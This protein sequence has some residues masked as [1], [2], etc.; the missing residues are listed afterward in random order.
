[1]RPCLLPFARADVTPY[2]SWPPFRYGGSSSVLY[3]LK[4]PCQC[5]LPTTL[6]LSVLYLKTPCN[7]PSFHGIPLLIFRPRCSGMPC[8]ECTVLAMEC[9]DATILTWLDVSENA[10]TNMFTS[11][12]L[13]PST[14][15]LQTLFATHPL[16]PGDRHG[17]NSPS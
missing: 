17:F 11:H 10:W 4:A 16:E 13:H 15:S 14:A 6:S 8:V 2:H 3:F 12:M 9:V 5:I 1:M 7:R